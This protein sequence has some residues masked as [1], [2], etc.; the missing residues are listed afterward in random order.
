MSFLPSVLQLTIH[1]GLSA[2]T[3]DSEYQSRRRITQ[4]RNKPRHAMLVFGIPV[5]LH[6]LIS[7]RS[8][9]VTAGGE[10]LATSFASAME[11]VLVINFFIIF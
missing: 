10:A 1:E 8:Y 2:A 5:H 11:G 9:G 4:R 7:S 3:F 6:S